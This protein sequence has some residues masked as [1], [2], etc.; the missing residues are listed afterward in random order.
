M[1]NIDYEP[2]TELFDKVF[3]PEL[4]DNLYGFAYKR[5]FNKDEAQDLCHEI[6]TEIL[7]ALRNKPEIQNLN[8]YIWR[9][10]YNTYSSYVNKQR[11]KQKLSQKVQLHAEKQDNGFEED[12]LATLLD[13]HQLE[14][15]HREMSF[16][17]KIYR[18]VM[19][20]FYLEGLSIAEIAKRLKI[21]KKRIK[22]R[23]FSARNRIRKEVSTMNVKNGDIKL[24]PNHLELIGTGDFS[25]SAGIWTLA[26]RLLVQN[27]L[28]ACRQTAKTAEEI[29]RELEIPTV[30]IEDEMET[31]AN[32]GVLTN[33]DN[34]KYLTDFIIINYKTQLRILSK[35][36]ECTDELK[37]IVANYIKQNTD[38]IMNVDYLVKP[39]SLSFA[40]WSLIPLM[41]DTYQQV[42]RSLV[43]KQLSL[44]DIDKK[45]KRK[46]NYLGYYVNPDELS[47]M[48]AGESP[49]PMPE[50]LLEKPY[51]TYGMDGGG[52]PQYD[53]YKD[54]VLINFYGARLPIRYE[55]PSNI[56]EDPVLL[57]VIK[58]I[59]GLSIASLSEKEQ[60]IAAKALEKNLIKKLNNKLY[61]SILVFSKEGCKEFYTLADDIQEQIQPLATEMVQEYLEIIK[62]LP[63]H[64]Y[65][66]ASDLVDLTNPMRNWLIEASINDN[67]LH[68]PDMDRC[69][70]AMWIT[71]ER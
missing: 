38:K 40:L 1:K 64:L 23:L 7:Q 36:H 22:Q 59:D 53:K 5:S 65:C 68:V 27:I 9:I 42:I 46:W 13:S 62:S 52:L 44:E 12:L 21:P 28:I 2:E 29:A 32:R 10:A 67:L 43:L 25:E 19:V 8:A 15:I 60:E 41:A 4:V 51:S 35:H 34:G 33:T 54:I 57:M 56:Y 49:Y 16:L 20:M 55:H 18:D 31:L 45:R 47:Q 69:A 71:V 17:G 14:W 61:L 50:D 3:T 26:R 66:Q 6:I 37:N 58:C 48:S 63:P 39:E 11:Q 30:F 24:R 70:E